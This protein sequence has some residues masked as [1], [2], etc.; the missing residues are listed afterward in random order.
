M[1]KLNSV[2]RM[3]AVAVIATLTPFVGSGAYAEASRTDVGR[4]VPT[5]CST[6]SAGEPYV[7][8]APIGS[9]VFSL[10]GSESTVSFTSQDLSG[11]PLPGV[12]RFRSAFFGMQV[13]DPVRFC[14]SSPL[15]AIPGQATAITLEPA[16]AEAQVDPYQ[17]EPAVWL[18]PG[19]RTM[20]T[21]TA[22]F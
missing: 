22:S 16:L 15:L 6:D 1:L 14:G 21:V 2:P 3:A 10:I 5:S 17:T 18:C 13:G 4:Y 12:I 19:T 9:C 7:F 11:L 20:G 8:Y